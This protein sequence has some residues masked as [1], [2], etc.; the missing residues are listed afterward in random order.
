MQKKLPTFVVK[1]IL[2]YMNAII[3]SI[4][5]V[6]S[7][8]ILAT[9]I[10]IIVDKRDPVKSLSWISV[11]LFIPLIGL[12]LYVTFGQ[13]LRRRRKLNLKE[14]SMKRRLA[15]IADKQMIEINNLH[16]DIFPDIINN[17]KIIRL[18]LFNNLCPITIDNNVKI[19][20]DAKATLEEIK[21]E[22]RKA[23]RYIHLE[24]YILENGFMLDELVEILKEKAAEGVEVKLIFDAV[25]SWGLKKSYIRGLRRS[26][27]QCVSF[28]PVIFPRFTRRINHRNHRKI[29]VIDG[30]VGFTGGINI[31]D[32]YISGIKGI[33]RWRD[34]HLKLEGSAVMSLETIFAADWSF[35]SKETIDDLYYSPGVEHFGST[36]IQI[37]SSGPDSDWAS[38]MQAFFLAITTAKKHIYISTPYFIPTNAILTALKVASMSG[39]DVK[40]LIP[41]RA[42]TRITHWAT[43]SYI[44]ELLDA[45]ICVCRYGG[46]FN[47]SK[48]IM[49]DS[50]FSSVGTVNMDV[51]SFEDNFE[52]TAMIYD[53]DVTME[54]EA[55]FV[56]DVKESYSITKEEWAKNRQI[57][58]L[59]EGLARLLSPLL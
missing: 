2:D 52:V 28:F 38:I 55:Q 1:I 15:R 14:A 53:K 41:E 56:E 25:G 32:R 37:A 33:G 5:G 39:V 42:D 24:Y 51:R 16:F 59:Y 8:I 57:T 36:A 20:V 34:T 11:I 13:N 4:I 44:P 26:G 58:H 21:T 54:L 12:F 46:G 31:A 17:I 35:S 27:I 6:Y 9:I 22:L 23:K 48:T 3:S 47:H 43:R 7:F 18:L 30:L 19:L 40:I 29:I 10:A 50:V 49:I 45:G